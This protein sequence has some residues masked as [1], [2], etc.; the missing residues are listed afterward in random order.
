MPNLIVDIFL[1][2]DGFSCDIALNF[3]GIFTAINKNST[4]VSCLDKW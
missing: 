2:L 3:K 4:A 1:R